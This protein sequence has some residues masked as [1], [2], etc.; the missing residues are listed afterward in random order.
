MELL[1][2]N[3]CLVLKLLIALILV[4]GL[5]GCSVGPMELGRRALEAKHQTWIDLLQNAKVSDK[6][7]ELTDNA[8]ILPTLVDAQPLDDRTLT[9]ACNLWGT[10]TRFREKLD[11]WLAKGR[12][13]VI[14][15]LYTKDLNN[16]DLIKNNRFS[17][18]L[19][20][21][22]GLKTEP[23]NKELVKTIFFKDY[24][25]LFN[26]WQKVVALSFDSQW[27]QN[28][29]LVLDWP[30]GSREISLKQGVKL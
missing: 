21:N 10:D 7:F 30:Y 20:T 5:F 18:T 12:I 14:V 19:R 13:V 29:I 25:P 9:E 1:K 17:F 22:G 4:L 15:G 23:N 28:P 2:N 8:D 3:F 26:P 27:T 24:F 6:I 11:S 16:D